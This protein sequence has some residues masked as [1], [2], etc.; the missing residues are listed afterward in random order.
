MRIAAAACSVVVLVA[1]FLMLSPKGPGEDALNELAVAGGEDSVGLSPAAYGIGSGQLYVS[2]RVANAS[3][4]RPIPAGS[5]QPA[6]QAEPVGAPHARGSLL[7]ITNPRN[8]QAIEV[9]VAEQLFD[10]R[11]ILLPARVA[12]SLGLGDSMSVFVEVLSTGRAV[13][14]AP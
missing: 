9:R 13:G 5:L 12:D 4:G 1:A 6:E 14:F 7:R 2:R 10:E 3:Y 8:W 11:A